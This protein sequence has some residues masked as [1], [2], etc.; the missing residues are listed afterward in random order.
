[1]AQQK[2]WTLLPNSVTVTTVI[3]DDATF[4][5]DL[6]NVTTSECIKYGSRFGNNI[7]LV[8]GDP[9][10][11]DNIRFQRQSDS[12]D[13]IKF[14]ELVAINVR[15]GKFLVYEKG[16]WGINLGWS[17]TPKFEWQ[18]LGGTDGATVE[19]GKA[20]GLYSKVEDDYLMYES[21]DS[22]INLKWYKDSGKYRKITDAVAA[23]KGI[24]HVWSSIQ[25]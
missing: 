7:N 6:F 22:G 1:M 4:I 19:T 21:R 12:K 13:P 17:N 5:Y 24:A 20:I 23:G 15:G 3:P 10:K 14:G 25:R 8:W 2:D 16:R 11:S 18:F 9:E